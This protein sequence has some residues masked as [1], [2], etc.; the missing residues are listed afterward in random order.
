MMKYRTVGKRSRTSASDR[1]SGELSTTITS[2]SS[3][4]R[5]SASRHAQIVSW[6]R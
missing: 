2:M 1:S 5:P 4:C 3:S 6:E